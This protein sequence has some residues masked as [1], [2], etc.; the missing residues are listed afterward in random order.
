MTCY[1]VGAA[2]HRLL[3]SETGPAAQQLEG[4]E[5]SEEAAARQRILAELEQVHQLRERML[6]AGK[7]AAPSLLCFEA[8]ILRKGSNSIDSCTGRT[9]LTYSPAYLMSIF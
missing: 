5:L 8:K 1:V 6:Q 9:A 3:R 4:R 2:S 7:T